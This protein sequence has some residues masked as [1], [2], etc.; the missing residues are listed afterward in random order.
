[1][2]K[3]IEITHRASFRIGDWH[4]IPD[5]GRLQ[6]QGAE[7]KLE[8]KVMKVLQC[9]AQNPGMVV[10]REQLEASVWTGTVVG[11]DAISSSIIKLRKALGDNSRNPRYIETVSKKGYRLVAEVTF[12]TVIPK[13]SKGDRETE[14]IEPAPSKSSE[15]VETKNR[16]VSTRLV[17][18]SFGMIAIFMFWYFFN[19]DRNTQSTPT[20]SEQ[21][22]HNTPSIVVLPFK[23][24]SDDPQQEYFSDGI[25]DDII[26]DLSQVGALRVVARQSA[27]H[28]K[29]SDISLDDIA[30]DLGVLYVV[31]GS[32]QKAGKRIR[33]NVQLTD[34]E[35]G[36][37]L[38]AERFDREVNNV[39]AI[40]DEIT[41]RIIDAMFV[42]LS[43]Q[44]S[45]RVLTRTTN[46]FEAYDTFL[47]GL[48]HSRNRT[49]EGYELTKEAYKRAIELD[50]NYARVYGAMAVALTFAYRNQWTNLS[51]GEARERAL[52]LANKAIALDQS[53]PQIYWALGF[54]RVIRKEYEQAEAA[55][56]QTIKLSRNYA[57]GYGLLAFIANW[58]G[59][60][61]E[62]EHYIKKAME[63]NPYHT[64]DYPFNLG[65][66]YYTS[67]KYKEAVIVLQNALERNET[68]HMSRLFLAASYIRLLNLED[69]EWEIEQIKIQSPE[70]TITSLASTLPYEDKA[71]MQAF[72]ADLKKAGLPN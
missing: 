2:T 28:Y 51:I 8:P 64:Y 9:L 48:Q 22:V 10:S 52:M 16:S 62:A 14:A 68:A 63:L 56:K 47:R 33:I 1:M 40:Q 13:E 71:Q 44:V 39:F 66:A 18:A 60:A 19:A 61:A 32:V 29:D 58:R 50:P 42:T 15:I 54:V 38:W 34:V 45:E 25:T 12:D 57:D 65:L 6:R 17:A 67:G 59:K 24:L 41:R 5:S 35:K 3:T 55:A 30:R 46:N 49:K 70:T 43:D 11:Y 37:H 72:L 7:V 36:K 23:N 4:V 31:E 69:A 53:V 20:S 21:A 27:Y 26:T